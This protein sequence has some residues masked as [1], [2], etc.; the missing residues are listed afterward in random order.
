MSTPRIAAFAGSCRPA[1]LNRKLL[2]AAVSL[3]TE[4][5]AEVD[6][7]ELAELPMP[8]FDED[9]GPPVV[10]ALESVQSF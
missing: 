3:A 7:I 1:S 8:I 10:L 6:V 5:G 4:A 9:L 2:A